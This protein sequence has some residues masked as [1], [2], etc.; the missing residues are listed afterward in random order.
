MTMAVTCPKC[1]EM[2]AIE[3]HH[4]D[5]ADGNLRCGNCETVF[6]ALDQVK[7]QKDEPFEFVNP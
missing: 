4:L 6:N 7:G 2:F 5:A 3:H 1:K